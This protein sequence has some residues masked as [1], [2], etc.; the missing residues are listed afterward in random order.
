[1]YRIPQNI[2]DNLRCSL[3]DGYLSVKPL[4]VKAEDQQ[5]CGRCFKLLPTEEKDKCVRQIGLETLAEVLI[6][7]CRYNTWG[8][9]YSFSWCDDKDHERECPYGCEL[10]SVKNE[11]QTSIQSYYNTRNEYRDEFKA[12][13]D[14]LIARFKYKINENSNILVYQL[15]IK[16]NADKNVS[17]ISGYLQ[18]DLEI[19][20]KGTVSLQNTPQPIYTELKLNPSYKDNLYE[21]LNSVVIVKKR[22][23]NCKAEI[24]E[25]T[26]NCLLGHS[27][28]ENCK[29]KMC[30]VCVK[31]MERQSKRF[32]KNYEKGCLG[33]FFFDQIHDHEADCEYNDIKCPLEPCNMI[34]VLPKLKNHLKE[35]HLNNIFLENE[36]NRYFSTKDDNFVILTYDSIFKCVYFYYKS[37]VEIFVTYVGSSKEASKYFYEVAIITNQVEQKKRSKC[38][39]W[40][41]LM[42]EQGVIFNREQLVGEQQKKLNFECRIK[43]Y[44]TESDIYL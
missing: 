36:V 38:S 22:C 5:I 29:G 7:P 24:K 21:S 44:K 26:Y 2:L 25:D 17:I 16:G 8:C 20:V 42:L 18:E 28:C 35:D 34:D 23:A 4:M 12:E 37:F 3:C 10:L 33:V 40:N 6:F 1:M 14:D 43:I 19:T 15:K 27:C 13:S 32:C 9:D 41:N 39:H 31:T 30:T 11:S